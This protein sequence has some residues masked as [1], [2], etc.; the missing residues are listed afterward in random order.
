MVIAM[1]EI[2]PRKYESIINKSKPPKK[3]F[4]NLL[5]IIMIIIIL[6]LSLGILYK[7]NND[8]KGYVDKYLYGDNISFAKV[9]K[10]Y[11]KYLGGVLPKIKEEN[12]TM[13]FNEK[14]EYNSKED[15]YDG[16][17]LKVNSNYLVPILDDGMVIFM[18]YKEHYGNTV[19]IENLDGIYYWYG[20]I[21]NT[22]LRLYDYVEKGSYIGEV[23]ENLYLAFS[24]DDKF[25]NYEEYLK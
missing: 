24:K 1:N 12:T 17:H 16:V 13:V 20:N 10:F 4:K 15:Y 21:S 23:N 9:K 14:I 25:L 11:N 7:S 19:I 3:N 22:N 5:I 18:G 6:F 2:D 8:F